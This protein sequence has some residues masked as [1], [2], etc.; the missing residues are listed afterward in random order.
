MKTINYHS[1]LKFNLSIDYSQASRHK[2]ILISEIFDEE[3]W[4]EM[5][6]NVREEAIDE[7]FQKW[8]YSCLNNSWHIV[9]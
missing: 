9:S 6:E 1:T 4:N 3:E 2:I 7:V 5:S 8:M